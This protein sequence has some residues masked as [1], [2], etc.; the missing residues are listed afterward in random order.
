VAPAGP[1]VAIAGRTLAW[2]LQ[3]TGWLLLPA[4]AAAPGGAGPQGLLLLAG[5]LLAQGAWTLLLPRRRGPVL[6]AAALLLLPGLWRPPPSQGWDPA[7]LAAVLAHAGVAA[8]AAAA[9][10]Q[11]ARGSTGRMAA[12]IALPLAGAGL[13]AWLLVQQALAAPAGRGALL[14]ASGVAGALALG[15]RPGVAART[16]PAPAAP[17]AMREEG[18]LRRASAALARLAMLPMMCGMA[19]SAEW[20]RAAAL[21][22]PALLALHLAAMCVPAAAVAALAPVRAGRLAGALCGPLLGLGALAG[23]FGGAAGGLGLVLA[24]GAAWSL[25]CC[26][27]T[28]PAAAWRAPVLQALGVL[29]LGAAVGRLGPGALAGVQLLIGAAGA[30]AGIALGIQA[31]GRSRG[32]PFSSIAT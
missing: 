32:R 13:L 22:P 2:T 11:A 30:A 5:W 23:F 20:C 29:A 19:L 24:Q 15:L 31:A 28:A 14:A 6:L 4:L 16:P 8:C 7:W 21:A 25:A 17:S 12:R 18:A 27:G 9:A 1:G 10:R 3:L 26:A